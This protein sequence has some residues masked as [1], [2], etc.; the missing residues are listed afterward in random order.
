MI[1]IY[2]SWWL[3]VPWK[4]DL[5][6]LNNAIFRVGLFF[7]FFYFSVKWN[8][9]LSSCFLGQIFLTKLKYFHLML[10]EVFRLFFNMYLK[11]SS[12]AHHCWFWLTSSIV[13]LNWN[14][15]WHVLEFKQFIKCIV[16]KWWI[17]CCHNISFITIQLIQI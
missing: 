16:P 7:F 3:M 15:H 14:L 6:P 8:L 13:F 12:N 9:L 10:N 4:T 1:L 5:F 2:F 11:S 17:D